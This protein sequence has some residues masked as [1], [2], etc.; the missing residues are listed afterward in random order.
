MSI[1]FQILNIY[2]LFN[3]SDPNNAADDYLKFVN[4]PLYS[5]DKKLYL[6]IGEHLNVKSY[7]PF[8][9]RIREWDRLFP[10]SEMLNPLKEQCKIQ[11]I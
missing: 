8:R 4:W 6:E 1:S 11:T 10:I 5:E 7:A 3:F 2:F 9:D